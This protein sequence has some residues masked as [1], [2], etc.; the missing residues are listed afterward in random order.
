MLDAVYKTLIIFLNSCLSE[1]S[2]HA[3]M[4]KGQVRSWVVLILL[5]MHS[6]FQEI[7]NT[8]KIN[9]FLQMI[10]CLIGV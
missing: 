5:Q 10:V 2:I 6:N 7:K 4:T 8:G 9:W 1:Y 3:F